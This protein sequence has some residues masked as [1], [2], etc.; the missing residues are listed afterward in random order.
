MDFQKYFKKIVS[1]ITK[2]R[3]E[4]ALD[5]HISK[6]ILFECNKTYKTEFQQYCFEHKVK[7]SDEN[8]ML[9]AATIFFYEKIKA[10]DKFNQEED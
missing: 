6:V 5:K 1:A 9:V 3:K 2:E 7:A 4:A 8:E 10:F